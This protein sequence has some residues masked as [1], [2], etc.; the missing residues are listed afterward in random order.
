MLRRKRE[1]EL[2]LRAEDEEVSKETKKDAMGKRSHRRAHG[3]AEPGIWTLQK[4]KVV[5]V[6]RSYRAANWERNGTTVSNPIRQS[7]EAQPNPH[8]LRT[9][10]QRSAFG[11]SDSHPVLPCAKK[12]GGPASRW[13]IDAS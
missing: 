10:H 3:T 7:T 13:K 6:N 8:V 9:V 5:V 2:R 11:P 12:G 1:R 4:P